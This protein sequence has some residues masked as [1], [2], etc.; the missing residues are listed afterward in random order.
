MVCVWIDRIPSIVTKILWITVL[1]QACSNSFGA[2]RGE[3]NAFH[4]PT[5]HACFSRDF[6]ALSGFTNSSAYGRIRGKAE[7]LPVVSEIGRERYM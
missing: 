5:E 3:K 4:P 7:N 6:L 1:A 2:L